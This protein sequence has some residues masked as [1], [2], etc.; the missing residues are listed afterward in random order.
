M[1]LERLRNTTPDKPDFIHVDDADN[2]VTFKMQSGTLS[3]CGRNGCDVDALVEFAILILETETPPSA[4][5]HRH[6]CAKSRLLEALDWLRAA[7]KCKKG[8]F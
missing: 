1:T 6:A 4:R 3:E 5:R 2:L 7:K 8:A